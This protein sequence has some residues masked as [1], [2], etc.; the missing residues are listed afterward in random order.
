MVALRTWKFVRLG[1][2]NIIVEWNSFCLI[3]WA[4][5]VARPAYGRQLDITK[6]VLLLPSKLK[7]SF[8]LISTVLIQWLTFLPKRALGVQLLLQFEVPLCCFSGVEF[9]LGVACFLFGWICFCS[10]SMFVSYVGQLSNKILLPF[11]KKKKGK[12]TKISEY[13]SVDLNL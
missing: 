12:R 10:V 1:L 4:L 2:T 5:V 8:V 3:R 11:K 7:V 13:V 6:E 9:F